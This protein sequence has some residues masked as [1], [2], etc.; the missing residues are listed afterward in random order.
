MQFQGTLNLDLN[1]NLKLLNSVFIL[2]RVRKHE[3]I[4]KKRKFRK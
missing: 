3:Q 1:D 4:K 2:R